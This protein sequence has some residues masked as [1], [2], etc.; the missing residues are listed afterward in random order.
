MA[1]VLIP[2]S[3][4]NLLL[5]AS[6]FGPALTSSSLDR[7]AASQYTSSVCL[8]S[9]IILLL[10][11]LQLVFTYGPVVYAT[12][13]NQMGRKVSIGEAFNG[14][15]SRY[16]R[17]GL[18]FILFYIVLGVFFGAISALSAL[19][20]PVL[21]GLGIVAYIGIAAYAMLAP[22]LI[23]E[24]IGASAGVS[25]AWGLGKAR[26]W[27]NVGVIVAIGI[28][29]FVIQ[30][31]FSAL[32]GWLLDQI[33]PSTSLL[34]NQ[35]ANTAVSAFITIFTLPLMPIALTLLYYDTRTRLEGLDISL[36]TMDIPNPRPWNVPAPAIRSGLDRNDWR[37]II[38]LTVGTVVITLLFGALV[39]S[40]INTFVPLGGVRF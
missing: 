38:I 18:G 36:Q 14:R 2:V 5:T 4:V 16:G 22:V 10:S 30:L 40:L 33:L 8:S 6:F 35:I 9:V 27:T 7:N 24:N 39:T 21:V 25:R 13:E 15:S 1:L 23:L 37:N 17:L 26:F 28:I 34:A 12:S 19:C 29:S 32:A 11:V 20:P 31:A 3:V